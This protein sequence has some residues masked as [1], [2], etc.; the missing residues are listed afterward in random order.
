MLKPLK[1]RQFTPQELKPKGWLYTQLKL[2]AEGLAGNLDKF[3]PDIKESSWIGGDKEGWERVPYW[4][5]GFIPLAYILDDEDMKKRAQKYIDAILERQCEDGWLCPC[6]P[7]ERE[8]YDIWAYFLICKVLTVYHQC[9]GDERIENVLYKGLLFLRKHVYLSTVKN[10]GATR[11]YEALIPIFWLYERKPEPWLIDLAEVL[12][13][14]GI[15]YKTMFERWRYSEV[16]NDWNYITHVVNIAMCLKSD[17]LMS[18]IFGYD[19]DET[20]ELMFKI[21]ERD[22]GTAFGHFTGDEC[23]GGHIPTRG[24][25]LCSVVEAMY[26]YEQILSVSGSSIWADRLEYLTFNGLPATISPDM[27]THQYNQMVNQIQCTPVPLEEC[28]FDTTNGESHLFGLEPNFGCCTANMG[29]GFPKFALSTFMKTEKGIVAAVLSPCELNTK[30]NGTEVFC[31]MDTKYPFRD[32]VR[33]E[34]TAENDVEFEFSIR[35]PSFAKS[36]KID[37]VKVTDKDYYTVLRN[38]KGTTEIVMEMEFETEIVN[39]PLDMVVVRRGPLLYSLPIDATW[40]K[41]EYEKNGVER[42][43]PYCDYKITPN[44]PWNYAYCSDEFEVKLNDDFDAAFT[45]ENPPIMLYTKM[46]QIPWGEKNGVCN[47]QPDSRTPVSEP[48]VKKLIPYGST[49][50]RITE[51]PYIK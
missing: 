44:E 50:L 46:V 34:I 26:S 43:F 12:S 29:Q 41:W 24:S 10:W 16:R 3:W 23:L 7:E 47:A 32:T 40:E 36:V 33:F 35:I 37:G 51:I 45:P 38:F 2:Q 22:H 17:A 4:L 48:E 28:P 9:T 42:K 39:R 6:K 49:T 13:E 19:P 27:W 15:N 14:Q 18:R 31:K 21:L 5:D 20:P 1:F 30:I 8:N 11:W 25:E